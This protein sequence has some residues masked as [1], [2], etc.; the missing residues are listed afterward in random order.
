MNNSAKNKDYS[1]QHGFLQLVINVQ[2]VVQ[3]TTRNNLPHVAAY[4]K[5]GGGGEVLEDN[6]T[7]YFQTETLQVD[8]TLAFT[9]FSR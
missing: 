1:K 5:V 9:S 8:I 7:I 2:H 6:D 4:Q 3:T